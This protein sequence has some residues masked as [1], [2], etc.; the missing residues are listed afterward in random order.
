MRASGEPSR[1]ASPERMGVSRRTPIRANFTE[2]LP[3]LM[4]NTEGRGDAEAAG[5][6]P[7]E[8][9]GSDWDADILPEHIVSRV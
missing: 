9:S 7:V 5:G 6:P 8:E 4:T 1:S 3:Q 2:E